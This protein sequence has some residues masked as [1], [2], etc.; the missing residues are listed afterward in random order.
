MA[1]VEE[2]LTVLARI[3]LP[4]KNQ[5]SLIVLS[6]NVKTWQPSRSHLDSLFQSASSGWLAGWHIQ[7]AAAGVAH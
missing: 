6:A 5:I 7:R 1:A 4:V 3:R 2:H